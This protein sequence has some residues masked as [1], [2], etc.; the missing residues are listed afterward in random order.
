M[1]E[2]IYLEVLF[3]IGPSA[4]LIAWLL[5]TSEISIIRQS[6][7]RAQHKT[8]NHQCSQKIRWYIWKDAF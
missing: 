8:Q 5:P 3:V 7:S 6:N 1:L 2:G 4:R